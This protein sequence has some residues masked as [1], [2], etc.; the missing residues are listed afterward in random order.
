MTP[1]ESTLKKIETVSSP[2]KEVPDVD[3]IE[4]AL[5]IDPEVHHVL[6]REE[7]VS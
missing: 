7:T 5:G 3:E 1:P 4:G 6:T 2:R